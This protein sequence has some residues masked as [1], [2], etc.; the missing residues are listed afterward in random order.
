MKKTLTSLRNLLLIVMIFSSTLGAAGEA[1]ASG[2]LPG[3][4]E[5]GYGALLSISGSDPFYALDQASQMRLDWVCIPFDWERFM[6]DPTIPPDFSAFTRLIQAANAKSL[7]VLVVFR[8]PPAWAMTVEGPDA[9]LTAAAIQALV[10]AHPGQLPAIELFPGANTVK[11]W[12]TAANP[13]RY[14][15][16]LQAA[17]AA[18][19]QLNQNTILLPS[20]T[21]VTASPT[22]GD[23]DD[24]SFLDALYNAGAQMPVIGIRFFEMTGEPL[25]SPESANLSVL[26][27]YEVVRRFMLEK[28][29]GK[30]RIWIT[31]FSWPN[32]ITDAQSQAKWLSDAYQLLKAQLY[33]GAAFF[34]WLNL[35]EPSDAWAGSAS[36]IMAD[37]STHPA[38]QNLKLM[39][40]ASLQD[41]LEAPIYRPL[42]KKM[43]KVIHYKRHSG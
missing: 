25:A 24:L 35:P 2:G 29:M 20:L 33:I 1:Q 36:L 18:I 37:A 40:S 16:I 14:F 30:D 7:S 31:G 26:R 13:A 42:V 19:A 6:P 23:M 28:G 39:A 21:P 32:Q 4:L 11:A 17:Q 34:A 15:E 10:N 22:T 27:H 41:N 8:H 9:A 43:I 5:F 12:G 38:Y 3:S